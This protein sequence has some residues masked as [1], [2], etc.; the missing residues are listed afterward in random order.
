MTVAHHVASPVAVCDLCGLPLPSHPVEGRE[1][2]AYCCHGCAHV[3]EIIEAVGEQSDAGRL[4]LAAARERGLISTATPEPPR[5]PEIVL[6]DQARGEV[7]MRVE[8]LACPSCAWLVESVL[9]AAPGV[10]NAQVDYLTDTARVAFDL[11][12]SSQEALQSAVAEAGYRLAPMESESGWPRWRE[13]VRL[14]VAAIIAMNLMAL[15]FVGYDSFLSGTDNPFAVPL[16]WLQIL[17]AVPVVGWCAQ[18]I[19][20]RA[21]A[22]LRLGRVVMETLLSLGI[23]AAAAL[24]LVAALTQQPHLYLETVTMLVTLSLAGRALERRFKA[25][26]AEALT[27][28][29]DFTP[30]KARLA[31]TGHFVPLAEVSVGDQIAVSA[32]ETVPLDLQ[33]TERA[34]VREGLLTGEPHPIAREAGEIVLAGSRVDV[35]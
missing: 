3:A 1:G 13:T 32:D 2:R 21:W 20:R 29:L 34:I 16:A 15:A 17:L 6:P 30:T 23:L 19:Y 10:A 25:R 8:G 11:R 9:E 31:D 14:S 24:S 33:L 26:A 35:G 7:R 22:A 28:L 4:A 18:P 12:T 27:D 5:S